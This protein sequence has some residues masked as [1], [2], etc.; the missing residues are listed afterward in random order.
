MNEQGRWRLAA[1]RLVCLSISIE[2]LKNLNGC[3]P[4]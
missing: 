4:A 1:Q 2:E 3:A